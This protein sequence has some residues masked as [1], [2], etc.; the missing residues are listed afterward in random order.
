MN[1]V[2]PH[3]QQQTGGTG[4]VPQN[5]NDAMRLADMMT[6]AKTL[7]EHLRG[8]DKVGD[9][10]MVVEQAMRWNMSPFAVAQCTSVISGKLMFEGKLVAAAVQHSGIIEGHF[11]YKFSG[12][13]ADRKVTV[14][15]TR[16]GET[17]PREFELALKDAKTNNGMWVKQPDQQLVYAGTRGWARRWAPGVMLGV[18]APEEFDPAQ[19]PAQAF[20][21]TTIDAEPTRMA[22]GAHPEPQPE[23]ARKKTVAEFLDGLQRDFDAAIVAGRDEV[24]RLVASEDVQKA[25]DRFINGN[26][27]RLDGMIKDALDRTEDDFPGTVSDRAA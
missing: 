11:D 17:E 18:Y 7:P 10:L 14:L 8:P 4:L 5:M 20:D 13:G 25:L 1:A 23:Q 9:A 22:E 16:R 6:R 21:G 12:V 27:A 19:Q 3:T 2:V 15:A 24:D 26:K